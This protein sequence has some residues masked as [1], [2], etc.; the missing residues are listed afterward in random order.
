MQIIGLTGGSGC[1]KSIVSK[2][3]EA[4][5]ACSIDTDS[6]YHCMISSPSPCTEALALAFGNDILTPEGAVSRPILAAKVF[7]G[8]SEETQRLSLLN[9]ITHHQILSVV[10]DII[11][12]EERK[13]T[14]AALVDAPLLFESGFHKECHVTV[15]VLAPKALRLSRVMERDGLSYE[16]ALARI[17]AQPNDDFYKAQADFILT[18]DG[19]VEDLINKATSFWNQNIKKS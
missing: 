7:C 8:G 6:I 5:G 3:F 9:E 10:R 12:K 17:D 19:T 14:V 13:G 11:A 4:L 15:A 2:A 18:N 16:A 1:G